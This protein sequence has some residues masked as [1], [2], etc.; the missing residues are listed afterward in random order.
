MTAPG[1]QHPL[2]ETSLPGSITFDAGEGGLPRLRVA[3]P[4]ASAEIYLQ[5]AQITSWQPNG[6]EPVLWLSGESNFE[7]G[8]PIRGGVP[9]CFPWFGPHPE[10]K[11]HGWARTTEWTVTE[12]SDDGADVRLVFTLRDSPETRASVWPHAFEARLEVVVGARLR[13]TLSVTNRSDAQ[14]TYTD[15]LHTYFA[16]S[17]IRDVTIA[18]LDGLRYTD[19]GHEGM[20]SGDLR[21]SG[22]MTRFFDGAPET[23][24][25][26]DAVRQ[27]RI[28]Q[29]GASNIIVWNPWID[30]SSSMADFGDDEWRDMI[31]V[32]TG[33]IRTRQVSLAPGE[34]HDLVTTFDVRPLV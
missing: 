4:D 2:I 14:I 34:S 26:A 15:A 11:Q 8:S 27:V 32:E 29:S 6:Q 16:V 7:P 23:T 1:H 3:G 9:I 5:G 28:T 22:P 17:D 24:V 13:L 18:G 12:A 30:Q 20:L 19:P 33:N 25:L 31:C 21:L 10:A